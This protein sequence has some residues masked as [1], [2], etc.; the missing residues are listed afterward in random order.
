MAKTNDFEKAAQDYEV[1]HALLTETRQKAQEISENITYES[2]YL[3]LD[4][5]GNAEDIKKQL[6]VPIDT[7]RTIC[8]VEAKKCKLHPNAA[9]LRV[10]SDTQKQLHAEQR[11]MEAK[12]L[13]LEKRMSYLIH[14]QEIANRKVRVLQMS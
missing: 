7:A 9:Q 2:A 13:V 12:L 14:T 4:S 3:E 6:S 1:T 5:A 8:Y 10:L 11:K